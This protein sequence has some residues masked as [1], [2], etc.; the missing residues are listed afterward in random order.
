MITDFQNNVSTK[1]QVSKDLKYIQM[2][3][4]DNEIYYK[5]EG[6]RYGQDIYSRRNNITENIE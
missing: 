1:Y 6:Q 2:K 3:E 5:R 4:K